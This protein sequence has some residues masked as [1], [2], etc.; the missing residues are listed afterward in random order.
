MDESQDTS[1]FQV[2]EALVE[3][4]EASV[5]TAQQAAKEYGISRPLAA[6]RSADD[7]LH[8]AKLDVQIERDK[9]G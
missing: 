9:R 1:K 7:W 6:L 2:L 4:A 8:T 5:K 3:Q